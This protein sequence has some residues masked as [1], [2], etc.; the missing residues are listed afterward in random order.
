MTQLF[1]ALGLL[2][3]LV[4]EPP[5]AN[6]E[7]AALD[8]IREYRARM[9]HETNDRLRATS[10]YSL[11]SAVSE[12]KFRVTTPSETDELARLMTDML[13]HDPYPVLRWRAADFLAEH[14]NPLATEALRKKLPK[15]DRTSRCRQSR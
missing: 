11:V 10:F 3:R 6:A 7:A 1:L 2:S 4:W 12:H 14:P 5:A 15:T 9:T 8:S 13:D